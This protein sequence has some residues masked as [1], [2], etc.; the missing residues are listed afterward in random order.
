MS[1]ARILPA[2]I[3]VASLRRTG[4]FQI[5]PFAWRH[6]EV[7]ATRRFTAIHLDVLMSR[8]DRNCTEKA[9]A[10]CHGLSVQEF[11]CIIF[12]STPYPNGRGEN[13]AF[14][15]RFRLNSISRAV[16]CAKNYRCCAPGG[17]RPIPP[18]AGWRCG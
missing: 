7:F 14:S 2:A 18:C 5:A 12:T 4:A 15:H 8:Q 9:V 13:P 3:A 17:C 1:C 16:P 11:W 10:G 6:T